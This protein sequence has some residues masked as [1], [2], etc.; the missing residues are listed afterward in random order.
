MAA[1]DQKIVML[2]VKY[3]RKEELTEKENRILQ[4]MWQQSPEH[5]KLKEQFGD[6]MWVAAE[7]AKMEPAPI[8]EIWEGINNHLDE[9]GAPDDRNEP[10]PDWYIEGE[11][12]SPILKHIFSLPRWLW[13]SIT[14]RRTKGKAIFGIIA[15]TSIVLFSIAMYYLKK[16]KLN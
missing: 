6:P 13:N 8:D 2:M 12:R 11:E 5:Q 7:L 14:R 16:Y 15:I 3:A 1:N 9:I 10:T 4:K